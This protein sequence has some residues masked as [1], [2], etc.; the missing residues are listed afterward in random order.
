MIALA[1]TMAAQLVAASVAWAGEPV[2][3]LIYFKHNACPW[4]AVFDEEVGGIYAQTDEGRELP[5][6]TVNTLEDPDAFADLQKTVRL[7]PTFVILDREGKERGR[8]RG[9]SH[10][11]FWQQLGELIQ[12]LRAQ[13]SPGKR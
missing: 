12:P 11:F 3:R 6:T 1:L 10:D 7:V 2:G 13:S 4:C 5:M 8:L 9:Y